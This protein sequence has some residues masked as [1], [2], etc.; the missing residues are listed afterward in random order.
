MLSTTTPTVGAFTNVL[1]ASTPV[2]YVTYTEY[3][4]DLSAY[5]GSCYIAFA[6]NAAPADGWYLYVDD[7]TVEDIPAGPVFSIS[8]TEWNFGSTLINSTS[9]KLF[10][11]TNAGVGTLTI[12]TVAVSGDYFAL[13]EPFVTAN[14]GT[15]ESATF[16]V[17][18]NPSVVG[19][20]TGTVTITDARAVSTVDLEGT[21]YDPT[22][23]LPYTQDFNGGTSLTAINW[24]GDMYIATPH[25]TDGSNGLYRNL[26]SSVPS[27]NA[28]T[29]PIGPMITNA[30]LK[31]DYRFVNYSSYPANAT[32][33]G[34]GDNLQIQVSTDAGASYTT[35]Y[36]IDQSNHVTSTSFANVRVSLAAYTTGSIM[37]RF[38][39]T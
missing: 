36:T 14:L 30:Q 39:G 3:E 34:A 1:M 10:T 18:Y 9:S 23:P 11:I 38:L 37:I 6:R 33:L 25:G 28:I 7:V 5:S 27:C 31:F 13:A 32:P 22:Q 24:A 17:N 2:N 12:N 21:C 26:W 35:V 20:H 16:T 29:P 15:G 8:P 19:T 4:I